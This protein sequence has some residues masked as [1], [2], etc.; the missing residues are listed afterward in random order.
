MRAKTGA[1][2][3]TRIRVLVAIA[4]AV[5]AGAPGAGRAATPRLGVGALEV[6]ATALHVKDSGGGGEQNYSDADPSVLPGAKNI[7]VTS[8]ANTPSAGRTVT[9]QADKLILTVFAQNVAQ[10]PVAAEARATI[11]FTVGAPTTFSLEHNLDCGGAQAI[12]AVLT[13]VFTRSCPGNGSRTL[14]GVLVPGAYTLDV[15]TNTTGGGI[16]VGRMTLT[17]DAVPVS[18]TTLVAS[19]LPSSRAVLVGTPATFFASVINAGTS[20]AFGVG[21]ALASIQSQ[22]TLTFNATDCTTNAVVG[23]A[24]VPVNIPP[25]GRACF[26]VA[27]TPSAALGPVEVAFDFAGSNAAPAPTFEGLNTLLLLASPIPGPDVVALAATVTGDGIVTIAGP[28]GS[29]AFSVAAVN[30]G[31]GGLIV[32]SANTHGQSL[33]LTLLI[34][35][36]DPVTAVC[37]AAPAGSVATQMNASATRTFSIFALAGGP[38]A[39]DPA[40]HRIFVE[41]SFNGILV[42]RTS[43]AVRT[44]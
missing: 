32:A 18:A 23:G 9:V 13:G 17:L 35:E 16:T 4:L 5:V 12:T 19:I 30:V 29:E 6:D 40:T 42:G 33:G 28:T 8:S 24:G 31:A 15:L 3:R 36:S 27:V 22:A 21:V 11:T 41:F 14:D 1:A 43:V 38:V 25:G 7:F 37:N 2:M 26:V 39:F 44:L 20:Q 10:D 34:C